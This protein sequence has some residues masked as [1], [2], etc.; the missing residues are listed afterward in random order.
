MSA[1]ENKKF[2]QGIFAEMAGGNGRALTDAMADDF[3]WVV[4][5]DSAWSGTWGSKS[6]VLTDLLLPLMSQFAGEY[7]SEVDLILADGDHV[8]VQSR[9]YA[10][11]KRGESYHQTYCYIFKVADGRLTEVTEF[12][13]TALVERVLE[14]LVRS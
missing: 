13:D 1:D 2:V 4:P 11:T 8:V 10:T 5:G 3:R 14:P 7:R 6:A 9:G 12:C